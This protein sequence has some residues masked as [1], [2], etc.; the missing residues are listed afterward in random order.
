VPA[1]GR[2]G[3][4]NR[5]QLSADSPRNCSAAERVDYRYSSPTVPKGCDDA[6][7]NAGIARPLVARCARGDPVHR[8]TKNSQN[9]CAPAL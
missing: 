5:I 2:A 9:C 4:G 6:A 8:D 7:P 1:F 3:L